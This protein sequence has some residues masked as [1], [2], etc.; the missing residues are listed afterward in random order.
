MNRGPMCLYS[1]CGLVTYNNE[2]TT[3]L[4]TPQVVGG[5]ILILSM[6]FYHLEKVSYLSLTNVLWQASRL[7]IDLREAGAKTDRETSWDET[8]QLSMMEFEG[9]QNTST[10]TT[11]IWSSCRVDV[12]AT[13]TSFEPI[14]IVALCITNYM[15]S[16]LKLWVNWVVADFLKGFL[17]KTSARW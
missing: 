17:I 3:L 1:K 7:I 11:N 13:V 8:M 5:G 15:S 14:Q 10:N 12:L 6:L 9:R 16:N 4:I 2:K